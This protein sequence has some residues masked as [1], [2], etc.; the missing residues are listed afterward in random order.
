MLTASNRGIAMSHQKPS[1]R[2]LMEQACV[3]G[4]H[5]PAEARAMLD[6]LGA[7]FRNSEEPEEMTDQAVTQA[8]QQVG[9]DV[10]AFAKSTKESTAEVKAR[11]LA[12]EQTVANFQPGDFGPAGFG[13]DSVAALVLAEIEQGDS[14]FASL[15]RGNAGS[16][17]FALNCGLRAAITH[18][19]SD[20]YPRDP[21]RNPIVTEPTGPLTFI[22]ASRHETTDRDSVEAVVLHADGEAAEQLE[23]GLDKQEVPIEGTL[24]S[25]QV[26]TFAGFET[27]SNQ[28]LS[29]HQRLGAAINRVLS[30]KVLRAYE[31]ALILGGYDTSNTSRVTGLLESATPFVPT[32]ADNTPDLIGQA[33]VA[34]RKRGYNP[35][36]ILMS[37]ELW[38][39][40]ST[41]KTP[42]SE[43]MYYFGNPASPASPRLWNL[44]VVASEWLDDDTVIVADRS[45]YAIVDRQAVS[46]EMSRHHAT[47]FTQNLTTVL[48]ELRGT[49]VVYDTWAVSS[50]EIG[51]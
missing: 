41:S 7:H 35:D 13:G 11:L 25:F 29:D 45:R 14:A 27:I 47:N 3:R 18:D 8:L 31:R 2:E 5:T 51:T 48:S 38:H 46:V 36:L 42:G 10:R 37:W 44:P 26:G 32:A 17:R 1:A 33:I 28:V 49:L 19:G 16:A 39:Q 23:E 30:G 50:I 4:G 21:K 6:K 9:Q 34:Q 24:R 20:G 43:K 40:I 15:L 12:V 22:E